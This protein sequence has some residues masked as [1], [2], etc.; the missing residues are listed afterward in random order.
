MLAVTFENFLNF[1]YSF[2]VLIWVKFNKFGGGGAESFKTEQCSMFTT[3]TVHGQIYRGAAVWT[4]R[5]PDR[6]R[7]GST[8]FRSVRS[9]FFFKA[10]WTGS[11]LAI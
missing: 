8:G 1:W 4:D 7:T 10:V 3:Y 6:D 9:A 5:G 11:E 2:E